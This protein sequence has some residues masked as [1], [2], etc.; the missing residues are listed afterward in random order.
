[1]LSSFFLVLLGNFSF[2]GKTMQIYPLPE[3]IGFLLS[4]VLL[5]VALHGFL[6]TLLSSRYTTKALL[7]LVFVV[8]SL[9]AY[10][11]DS[12]HVIIDTDMIRNAL[13][14]DLR[15]SLDLFSPTLLGYLLLLGLLPAYLI[16]RLPLTYRG[17]RREL[18]SKS[19]NLLLYGALMAGMLM[20][21][22]KHYTSFFRE[23]KPLRYSVNPAYWIYSGIKYL[24]KSYFVTPIKLHPVGLD[25]RI[26]TTQKPTLLI[27]VVG[28]ATRA[29]HWGLNGYSRDTTP[30][31]REE[32]VV[33]LPDVRSCATATAASVPCMFSMFDRAHFDHRKGLAYENLLDILKHTGGI[34]LLWRDN[35]SDSKGVALRIPYED[36][37][38]PKNNTLCTEDGECRDEGM[39]VGLDRYITEQNSTHALIVLHQMGNHGPAYYRR[40]PKKF[41]SFTPVCTTNQLEKCS[42]EAISN[43]YDN[44]ILHTD[45]FLIDTIALLKRHAST[46]DVGLIYMAD[47]GESLG[48]NGVYLHGMPYFMAPDAQTHVAAI[49]WFSDPDKQSRLRQVAQK[50]YSH[51]NLFHTVLGLFGIETALYNPQLDILKVTK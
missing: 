17:W 44:A 47:H 46:Y 45:S 33:N 48:E 20:L 50:P 51:D 26:S 10:F 2:F 40:Y 36:Y 5:L 7:I 22:S 31:L 15:E 18:L 9:T 1:L 41:E 19:V 3:N 30:K 35:N 23:H 34:S 32:G 11:M 38:S 24:K 16:Y 4:L 28:E 27:L 21:Y 42:R 13:Q 25:A 12:Y 6:F 29:D 49:M 37:K 39:L 43:A 8:S 14:T